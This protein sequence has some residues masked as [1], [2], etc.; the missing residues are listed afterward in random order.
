LSK[1]YKALADDSGI[2]KKERGK[3]YFYQ[4]PFLEK[5]SIKKNSQKYEF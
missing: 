1:K 3:Y 4:T 5:K 2:V